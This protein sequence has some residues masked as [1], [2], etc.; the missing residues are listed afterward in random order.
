MHGRVHG[1]AAQCPGLRVTPKVAELPPGPASRDEGDRLRPTACLLPRSHA[2][3]RISGA[4]TPWS[5]HQRALAPEEEPR[6]AALRSA[7]PHVRAVDAVE[8]TAKERHGRTSLR[9]LPQSGDM[10]AV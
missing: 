8:H 7:L 5:E 4:H 3:S 2:H 6:G 9:A 10:G 1:L